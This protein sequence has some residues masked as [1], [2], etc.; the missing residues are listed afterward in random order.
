MESAKI[1]ECPKCKSNAAVIPIIFGR[2]SGQLI[3]QAQQ[4]KVKLSGCMPGSESNHCKTCKFD[5]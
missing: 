2:P 1:P 5:F 4:G 3:E